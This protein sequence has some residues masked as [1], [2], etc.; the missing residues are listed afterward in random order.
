MES[1]SVEVGDGTR[2]EILATR[3]AALERRK[4]E[5]VCTLRRSQEKQE[6]FT[7]LMQLSLATK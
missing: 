7:S 2:F 5:G 4:L 6:D 3:G 1:G